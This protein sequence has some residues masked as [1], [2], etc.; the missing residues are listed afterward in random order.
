MYMSDADIMIKALEAQSLSRLEQK[1][2]IEYLKYS[3]F[4]YY[5]PE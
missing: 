1:K 4:N 2:K 5:V 3:N